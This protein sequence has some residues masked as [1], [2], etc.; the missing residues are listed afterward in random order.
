MRPTDPYRSGTQTP[1]ASSRSATPPSRK[2]PEGPLGLG[3]AV[4]IAL[5]NNPELA[6]SVYDAQAAQARE[7]QAR[8]ALL[9]RVWAEGGYTRFLDDQRLVPA[10]YNGE[11]GVFSGGLLSGD[12]VF[13]L[14]LFTGGR[15]V[16][17]MRA[18]DLMR[19]SA[20]HRTARTRDD[21]VFNV[22]SV[23]YGILAQRR[24]IA[25]LEFSRE[26]LEGHLKR[27]NDLIE[28]QKAA[29]VDRLRTEVRL[30]DVT[31]KLVRERN[32]RP[33]SSVFWRT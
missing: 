14:P 18:A 26:A 21:L 4:E 32:A 17:E 16:N 25:S 9:P 11:P 2:L 23:F 6:A 5:A 15:L 20:E 12:L 13:R 33:S 22:S 10:R 24:F 28:A 3:Q 30:S 27:V 29:G 1:V 7:D 19:Q 8:G 31:Q